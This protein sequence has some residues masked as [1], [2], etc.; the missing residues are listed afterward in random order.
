MI[1]FP[2]HAIYKH[3]TSIST[4]LEWHMARNQGSRWKEIWVHLIKEPLVPFNSKAKLL[5]KMLGLWLWCPLARSYRGIWKS[6]PS[7]P[8]RRPSQRG[9]LGWA[10]TRLPLLVCWAAPWAEF[11]SRNRMW[12]MYVKNLPFNAGD[13]RDSGS[14]PRLERSPEEGNGNPLEH[15]CLENAIDRGARW[16]T[17][18]GVAKSRTQLSMHTGICSVRNLKFSGCYFKTKVKRNRWKYC[19]HNLFNPIYPNIISTQ[20]KYKNI[21]EFSFSFF[22]S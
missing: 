20:N 18:H 10:G 21:I 13:T 14:T 5:L 17:V 19:Y 6:S 1:S 4:S 9:K 22:S 8:I 15:S 12:A 3:R 2:G 7:R 16:T 11:S